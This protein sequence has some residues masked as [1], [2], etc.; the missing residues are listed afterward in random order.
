MAAA[1]ASTSGKATAPRESTSAKE[2]GGGRKTSRLVGVRVAETGMVYRFLS[3]VREIKVGD[4]VLLLGSTEE[5]EA[6]GLVVFVLETRGEESAVHEPAFTG[7]FAKIARVLSDAERRFLDPD[8]ETDGRVVLEA[9]ARKFCRAKIQELQLPMRL[10]R[11]HYLAGGNRVLISFTA[12]NRVDFRELVRIL[13]SHLKVRVEMRHIG[14]RDESKLLG[15]LGLCGREFCCTAHLHRFHPVSVRM[16]KNQD[17]SLNPEGISGVCGRLLCCLEYENGTYQALREGLPKLKQTVQTLDGRQGV[18]CAVHPL[19]GTVEM[20]LADGSRACCARCDLH[21]GE[22]ESF[23]SAP[24][25][26]D[27]GGEPPLEEAAPRQEARPSRSAQGRSR[28]SRPA[29]PVAR[30]GGER[31]EANRARGM[32]DPEPTPEPVKAQPMAG[33]GPASAAEGTEGQAVP[34]RKRRRRR[35]ASAKPA[36]EGTDTP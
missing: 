7:G 15:G 5:E 20:Q 31:P 27:A 8:N 19:T 26:P 2:G 10:S 17:L 30:G 22:G 25:L 3:A 35:R 9:R 36:Q 12:E 6:V 4:A 34:A 18:V 33:S 24:S 21:V 1:K 29:P 14:V 23:S 11:V 32:V 16:A 28:D 13:G